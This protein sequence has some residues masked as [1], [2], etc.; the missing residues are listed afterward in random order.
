[1]LRTSVDDLKLAG[2]RVVAASCEKH[3]RGRVGVQRRT[4]EIEVA[5]DGLCVQANLPQVD[6]C[7]PRLRRTVERVGPEQRLGAI[8]RRRFE[9]SQ[10]RGE[11]GYVG[12]VLRIVHAEER[13]GEIGSKRLRFE[14]GALPRRRR[15]VEHRIPGRLVERLAVVVPN[16]FE[17]PEGACPFPRLDEAAL[18]G[19]GGIDRRKDFV[20]VARAG[21]DH[22]F[23]SAAAQRPRCTSR[24]ARRRRSGS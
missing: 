9:R 14:I 18:V 12:G 21:R 22:L 1:M 23:E 15:R 7:H 6:L 19:D 17:K 2:K 24:T 11:F 16:G 8:V 5:F 20:P 4:R 3:H 10:V 13:T